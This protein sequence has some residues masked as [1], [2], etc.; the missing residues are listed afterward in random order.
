MPRHFTQT[1][2]F[3]AVVTSLG[4]LGFAFGPG[5]IASIFRTTATP[6]GSTF[7]I[8]FAGSANAG[9]GYSLGWQASPFRMMLSDRVTN[10][11]SPNNLSLNTWYFAAMTKATGS[12]VGRSHIYDYAAGTWTHANCATAM[13]NSG[14]PT[15]RGSI[16][17]NGSGNSFTFDGDISTVGVWNVELTDAQLEPMAFDLL[18]W[19]IVQPKGLW[20][21]DQE[22][23]SQKVIDLSGNGANQSSLTGT[24]LGTVSV[25]VF[26]YGASL[27]L[28]ADSSAL[29][30]SISAP[31]VSAAESLHSPTFTGGAISP[32][33]GQSGSISIG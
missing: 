30:G 10:T 18:S 22:T 23:T 1:N 14:V 27:P 24:S 25:P 7:F 29:A 12:V 28:N 4:A 26:S 6:S 5:T 9:P 2:T 15:T 32:Q 33:L 16:G 11:I 13:A 20:Q 19:F 21:L 31:F 3:D 17:Q 8:F